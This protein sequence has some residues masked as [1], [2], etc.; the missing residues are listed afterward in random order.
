MNWFPDEYSPIAHA[1]F[2]SISDSILSP[3]DIESELD[4]KA[5]GNPIGFVPTRNV[6]VC[7]CGNDRRQGGT[8]SD[9]RVPSC[10]CCGRPL[11]PL[12]SEGVRESDADVGLLAR[13]LR[14]SLQRP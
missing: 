5:R 10:P 7:E 4:R 9:G 8:D 3:E 12:H 14:A 11:R 2:G 6:E 1:E 13:L